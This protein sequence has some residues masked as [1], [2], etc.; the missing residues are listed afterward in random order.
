M[1]MNIIGGNCFLNGEIEVPGDKSISH[2]A[3]IL[4]SISEGK[5]IIENCLI[6]D[7]TLM[8]INCFKNL[9]VNIEIENNTVT[10]MG[11]GLKGLKAPKAVLYCGNSGTT[12]RLL[13][14]ILVAQSFPS[15]LKGDTSLNNRPMD[16]IIIPLR[17]MG[18]NIA[19]RE[20]R[21]LPLKI[22]PVGR[23]NGVYYELPVASAQVKSAILLA[24]I[25]GE[26]VTTIIEKSPSR[27]HTERMLKFF[28]SNIKKY[29][30]KIVNKPVT[31][32]TGKKIFVPGD[33]S[34]AAYFI[35]G[36]LILKGS[37]IIIKNVGINK[38]RTGIIE[39]LKKMGGYIDIANI[40][41]FNNEPIADL[42]VKHSKLKGVEVKGDIIGRLIDEIPILTIGATMASGKTIIKNAQEL[43]YKESNRIKVMVEELS[44]MG[45][46]IEELEDGMII[47]GGKYLKGAKLK[48][49]GD[50]RVLMALS[51]AALCGQGKTVLNDFNCVDISFPNYFKELKRLMNS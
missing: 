42:H 39:V 20:E 45:A 14:G 49:Y 51:I 47:Q 44:K 35:V 38:T 18:A 3:I 22:E 11:K 10:I 27:D 19:G 21:F 28:N 2:R 26:N 46:N 24:S 25:Y 36:A 13:S 17:I 8:T 33:I 6:S 9:G 32:L 48:S 1:D 34:S 7:D 5:T 31:N 4:G 50:H 16:R 30:N 23:L 15:I 41:T 29:D 12:A 40:R 43:K 37:D